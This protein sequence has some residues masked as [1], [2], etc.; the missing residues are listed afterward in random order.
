MEE[1]HAAYKLSSEATS[2]NT[3]EAQIHPQQ[4]NLN[5]CYIITGIKSPVLPAGKTHNTKK[6]LTTKPAPFV[7][8]ATNAVKIQT[9]QQVNM[10]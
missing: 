8:V 9:N 4:M 3:V 6:K 7:I 2:E 1:T 5:K 10:G